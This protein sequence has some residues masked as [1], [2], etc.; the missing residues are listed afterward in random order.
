MGNNEYRENNKKESG[1][2]R[3]LSLRVHDCGK[4]G[5][6]FYFIL[7]VSFCDRSVYVYR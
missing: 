3:I 4:G 6:D 2:G 7:S 5:W 1:L